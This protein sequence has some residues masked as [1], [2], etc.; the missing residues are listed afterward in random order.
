MPSDSW[1]GAC[2]LWLAPCSHSPLQHAGQGHVAKAQIWPHC[3]TA[4][5]TGGPCLRYSSLL[6]SFCLSSCILAGPHQHACVCSCGKLSSSHRRMRCFQMSFFCY[7]LRAFKVCVYITLSVWQA[8]RALIVLS[9]QIRCHELC[10]LYRVSIPVKISC[11]MFIAALVHALTA[12]W[13]G[14]RC[15]NV[16]DIPACMIG[17][18]RFLTL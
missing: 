18:G 5:L 13:M 3:L 1:S 8:Q 2:G 7:P 10:N 17:I 14:L 12:A 15:G 16:T 6:V 9:P 4:A 11:L